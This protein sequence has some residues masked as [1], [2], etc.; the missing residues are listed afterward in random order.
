MVLVAFLFINI[1]ISY[2]GYYTTYNYN[3]DNQL[4]DGF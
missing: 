4:S 3:N 2:Y 1:P